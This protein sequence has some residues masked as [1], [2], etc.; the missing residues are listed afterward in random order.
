MGGDLGTPTRGQVGVQVFGKQLSPGRQ[1]AAPLVPLL[2]QRERP[3]GRGM[4]LQSL[5]QEGGCPPLVVVVAQAQPG[6]GGQ[7]FRG[8]G[9][10]GRVAR[11]LFR[12][13]GGG[14]PGVPLFGDFRL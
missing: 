8:G 1:F 7:L 4:N 3:R 2:Q 9:G 10:V 12:F 14:F 13:G 6:R 11:G 5:F